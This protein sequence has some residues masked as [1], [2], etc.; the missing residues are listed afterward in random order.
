MISGVPQGSVVGPILFIIFI[1]DVC[2]VIVGN[3]RPTCKLYADDIKLYASVDF[4]GVS[5]DLQASLDDLIMW[6]NMWQLKVHINKCNVLRI[7]RNCVFV[8]TVLL[9]V[10]FSLV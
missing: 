8:V 10:T 4:N 7:G 9:M 3:T 1:N 6:S 5:Q 2:D